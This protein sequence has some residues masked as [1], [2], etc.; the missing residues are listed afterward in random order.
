MKRTYKVR[1]KTEA[2][3]HETLIDAVSVAVAAAAAGAGPIMIDVTETQ[4]ITITKNAEE[5]A[6]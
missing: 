6:S 1:T 3:E 4:S 2:T 5:P